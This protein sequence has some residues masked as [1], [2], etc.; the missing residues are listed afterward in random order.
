MALSKNA[1][2]SYTSGTNPRNP[3]AANVHIYQRAILFGA[4]GGVAP[5]TAAAGKYCVGIAGEEV[6]NTGG[7]AGD[8]SVNVLAGRTFRLP[9]VAGANAVTADDIGANCYAN[10]DESVTMDSSGK[11]AVGKVKWIDGSDVGVFIP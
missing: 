8:K 11:S 5:A 1:R 10:D 9:S 3:V 2:I 7:A 6:D 4:T